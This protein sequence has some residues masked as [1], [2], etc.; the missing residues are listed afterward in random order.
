[1][2]FR[3]A[4]DAVAVP[5]LSA[6][7]DMIVAGDIPV[8]V[9]DLGGLDTL[10]PECLA[11]VVGAAE[12]L[13]A[14]DRRMVVRSPSVRVRHLLEARGLQDLV[15][16]ESSSSSD[17][18]E[19]E[20]PLGPQISSAF[21]SEDDVIDGALR[22][23]V[24][25]TRATVPSA[26]GVSVSLRRHGQLA[27]VAATDRTILD[28]D[29]HQYATGEGPCIDASVEGRMFLAN[30]LTDEPRWPAF[31]PGARSLGIR[32][33]LSA[34][35]HAMDTPVGALNIYSRQPDVFEEQDEDL[36]SMFADETSAVLTGAKVNETGEQRGARIQRALAMR[37]AIAQAQGMI[38]ERRG[39][40]Q[41]DAYTVLR[42]DS[43][44]SGHSLPRPCRPGHL[45]VPPTRPGPRLRASPP[46]WLSNRPTPST[47]S[48]GKP[49]CP[50]ASCG[51]A[52]SNSEE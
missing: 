15:T 49:T 18:P 17:H 2:A 20:R 41:D 35:L 31:T 13:T 9:V 32:S 46:S 5:Q 25:L 39:L 6:L 30:S 19:S 22:M 28:M 50:G 37:E 48:G 34:P 44:A 43:Q 52:I 4:P 36:A 14:A 29:T 47:G 27:T 23:L 40:S 21:A 45:L 3:G 42:I 38:M 33:I 7:F 1:M 12:R 8:V 26:Q 10:T 24:A 51:C 16:A 11:Q